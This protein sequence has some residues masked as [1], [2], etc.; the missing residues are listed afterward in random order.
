MLRRLGMFA[1]AL[2]LALPTPVLSQLQVTG[3]G[4]SLTIGGLLQPQYGMSSIDGADDDFQIRRARLRAELD[5]NDFVSGRFLTEF[6]GGPGRILDAYMSLEFSE[7]FTAS[8]GQFKRAF[9]IFELPSPADLPEIERDGRIEGYSPCPAVG[10]ICSH[11]RLTEQL[12]F[13][14]RDVGVRVGGSL[15]AVTY[16]ATLTNGPG[17][18]TS[19][20]NDTKSVSGRVT[21]AVNQDV[22]ISG[23]LALHDYVDVA[24]NATALGFGGDVEVGTW[25]DGL[26]VRGS[27]VGGDNWLD[28]EAGTLDPATFLTFQGI[29]TYY[30]PLDGSRVVGIEPLGRLSYGDPNT[31]RDDDG[32]LLVTPGIM[33]YVTGR[34]RIGAN[35]D[36]YSPQAGD[37]EFSFEIQTTLYY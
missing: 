7:G 6:G 13:A 8:F 15:G 36:I 18:N 12:L 34:S 21:Y 16:M 30:F 27:L 25:R 28:L 20:E 24:G 2:L 11:G 4:A 23:Q 3:R 26:H 9:D 33:F 17:L 10:S 19:D 1:L 29:A 31:G 32:G 35:L 37:M 14:G 22:R 5:V